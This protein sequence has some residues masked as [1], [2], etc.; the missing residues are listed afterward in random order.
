MSAMSMDELTELLRGS[1]AGGQ[2]LVSYHERVPTWRGVYGPYVVVV[3]SFPNGGYFEFAVKSDE[4]SISLPLDH[5]K[6]R[7]VFMID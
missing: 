7:E 1:G 2:V 6:S 4:K 5:D 3:G